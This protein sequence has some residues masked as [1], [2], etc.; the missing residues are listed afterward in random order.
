M[1]PHQWC[2]GWS[3]SSGRP[4]SP[5]VTRGYGSRKNIFNDMRVMFGRVG[6]KN[7]L[8]FISYIIVFRRKRHKLQHSH[9]NAILSPTFCHEHVEMHL[10]FLRRQTLGYTWHAVVFCS[11]SICFLCLWSAAFISNCWPLQKVAE[12]STEQRSCRCNACFSS[13]IISSKIEWYYGKKNKLKVSQIRKY[14]LI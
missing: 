4:R 5:A 13:L 3:K 8:S 11:Q 2:A 6:K 10:L 9:W 7:K 12:S 14:F 1:T